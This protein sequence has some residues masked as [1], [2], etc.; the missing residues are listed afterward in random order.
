[1]KC[2]SFFGLF[3][4]L[5]TALSAQNPTNLKAI[6]Y[7]TPS[8]AVNISEHLQYHGAMVIDSTLSFLP[9]IVQYIP[10]PKYL[11][12]FQKNNDNSEFLWFLDKNNGR[13]SHKVELTADKEGR[14]FESFFYRPDQ[15]LLYGLSFDGPVLMTYSGDG[16]FKRSVQ[17]TKPYTK[18]V[19]L[20]N[21][22]FLAE[23]FYNVNE[24]KEYHHVERISESGQ[25]LAQYF[26]YNNPES[27]GFLPGLISFLGYSG[28]DIYGKWA[29][30]DT[31]YCYKDGAFVPKLVFKL[32]N[33]FFGI[34]EKAINEVALNSTAF[35][36]GILVSKEVLL[37]SA[38][39]LQYPAHYGYVNSQTGQYIN[40]SKT[41]PGPLDEILK[42]LRF[43]NTDPGQFMIAI[44]P[45][46]AKKMLEDNNSSVR[47]YLKEQFPAIVDTLTQAA[48]LGRTCILYFKV[49]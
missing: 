37:Y 23:P 5:V 43:I 4:L 27:Q 2:I 48:R 35:I 30:N 17:L 12:L 39:D 6:S 32:N 9:G 24:N 18:A 33:P 26:P 47:F 11:I 25:V 10:T 19:P 8:D 22:D 29:G 45:E 34:E 7:S 36:Q 40:S 16:Q 21:G 38:V 42:E 46:H 31:L 49:A 14:A 3:F 20:P 28:G 41:P 1:M 15:D 13:L 44:H